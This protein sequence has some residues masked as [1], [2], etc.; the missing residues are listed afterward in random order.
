MEG[1]LCPAP[2][3]YFDQAP[4]QIYAR[5]EGARRLILETHTRTLS[6]VYGAGLNVAT[7]AAKGSAGNQGT[8]SRVREASQIFSRP[9]NGLAVPD[10]A[11]RRGMSEIRHVTA[12]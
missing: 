8:I 11:H 3:R 6:A 5:G 7:P 2:L 4:K 9:R 12:A 10:L 1:W